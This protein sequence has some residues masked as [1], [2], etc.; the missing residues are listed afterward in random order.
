MEKRKPSYPVGRNVNLYNHCR[1]W[2]GETLKKKIELLYGQA[3]PLLG[4]YLEKS[5]IHKDICTPMFVAA[6]FTI[7]FSWWLS[8]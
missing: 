1:E 2:Y 5:I 4:I 8:W 6:L 3:N 7:G